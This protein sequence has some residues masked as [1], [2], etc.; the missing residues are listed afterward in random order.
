MRGNPPKNS[1]TFFEINFSTKTPM[2]SYFRGWASIWFSPQLIDI[3]IVY[4][5]VCFAISTYIQ[6]YRYSPP[7]QC[8]QMGTVLFWELVVWHIGWG[9]IF[10]V[11]LLPAAIYIQRCIN[12]QAVQKMFANRVQPKKEGRV[13]GDWPM[14]AATLHRRFST[15]AGAFELITFSVFSVFGDFQIPCWRTAG[16]I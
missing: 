8:K 2:S 11:G 5:Y 15:S 4:F 10:R 14:H 13:R 9:Y 12:V 3:T 1:H 7:L 16:K 6:D